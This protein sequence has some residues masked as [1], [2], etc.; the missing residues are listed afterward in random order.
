[1]LRLRWSP[2]A[3]R[4]LQRLHRFLA[5][6]NARAAD[7]AIVTIRAS[8]DVLREFTELGR[9]ADD[10]NID[11]RELLVPFSDSGYVVAYVKGEDVVEILDVR[12]Q[13]EAGY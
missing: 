10:L 9:W 7:R 12:H 13:R 3:L 8:V 11:H 6:K 1:M 5:A 4:D 2:R